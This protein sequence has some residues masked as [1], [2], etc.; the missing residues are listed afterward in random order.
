MVSVPV[1]REEV[2]GERVPVDRGEARGDEARLDEGTVSI[3]VREEEVE[4]RKAAGGARGDPGRQDRAPRG[5]P[6]PTCA[7]RT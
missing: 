6:G 7:A 5:A 2:R 3:P 4:I 1:T